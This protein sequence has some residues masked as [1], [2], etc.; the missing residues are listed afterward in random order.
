M[1]EYV[2]SGAILKCSMGLAPSSLV[3][4]PV[5]RV[6]NNNMPQANIM[7]NKPLMNILPFGLCRSLANPVVAAATSAAMGT[8]TPMPCIPNTPAPWIPGKPTMMVANQSALIKNCKL[9]CLWAG[10]ITIQM[11]GQFTVIE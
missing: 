2:C 8:L 11:P 1:A 5:N 7:D 4:M 10:L 6:I 3:V 9:M